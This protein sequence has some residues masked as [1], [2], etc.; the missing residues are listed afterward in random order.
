MQSLRESYAWCQSLAKR[1]AGNFYYSFLTLPNDLLREMC[2]LYAFMRL[3]DDLGDDTSVPVERRRERLAQWREDLRLAFD[4]RRFH[5]P[6]YPALMDVVGRRSIPAPYLYEVLDGIEADLEPQGFETFEE[7]QRY[8]YLVAGTVGLCCIHIWGYHDPR[9][10]E[11]AV[12]CGTA[13]QLTNI[14]RDLG[15]DAAMGRVYLPRSELARFQYTAD[16]LAAHRRDERFTELMR[17]QVERARQY[18]GRA[19]EL[20]EHLDPPGRPVLSAML[21]IYGGLLDQIERRRYDVFSRRVRLPAWRKLWIALDTI[22]RRR[23]ISR[24]R[25]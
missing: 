2:V 7:L 14:L 24:P 5:H 9:A 23:W 18:Y 4:G 8:C 21:R 11:R 25:W 12:D 17:F 16:D 22:V 6:L 10:V 15:E 3:S 1:T 13:F 19:Q 20:F